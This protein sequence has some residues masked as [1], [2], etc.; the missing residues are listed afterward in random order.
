MQLTVST[1][2]EKRNKNEEKSLLWHNVRASKKVD[3]VRDDTK[4]IKV[5]AFENGKVG[6]IELNTNNKKQNIRVLEKLQ[7]NIDSLDKEMEEDY[8]KEKGKKI[9]KNAV[10]FFRGVITFGSD[11][12]VEETETKSLNEEEVEAINAKNANEMDLAAINYM[13]NLEKEF[14]I[15]IAY[16]T[17]HS[18]EKTIHYHYTATQYNF[19]EHKMFTSGFR[20]RDMSKFGETLQNL[21]HS[22]FSGLGFQRGKKGSKNKHLDIKA[23]H[24]NEIKSLEIESM[25][26][27]K[28]IKKKNQ[29]K[30]Q[31]DINYNNFVSAKEVYDFKQD[32]KAG[33]YISRTEHEEKISKVKELAREAVISSK[34]EVKNTIEK[35]EELRTL[36]RMLDRKITILETENSG[37]KAKIGT[38]NSDLEEVRDFIEDKSLSEEFEASQQL[39]I[40]ETEASELNYSHGFS[41]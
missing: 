4:N 10:K 7:D 20:K 3:N 37:L 41:M 6:S 18:E 26:L 38:L 39:S 1:R 11:R 9:P 5:F 25:K 17:R 23:M 31:S 40:E 34:N 29:L 30:I 16:I 12:V 21:V 19:R 22:S 8:K 28:D 33:K 35:F 32:K 2:I 24:S 13:K 15:K 14:G 36:K 27:S